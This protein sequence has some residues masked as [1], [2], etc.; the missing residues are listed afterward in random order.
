MLDPRK[1]FARPRQAPDMP[2]R[3]REPDVRQAEADRQREEQRET[4]KRA[5]ASLDHQQQAEHDRPDA[6]RRDHSHAEAH[7]QRARV[8]G[9]GRAR[10]LQ[11]P[12]WRLQDEQA[13]ARRGERQQHH[14]QRD[15][16]ERILHRGAEQSARH[17]DRDAHRREH[18]RDSEHEHD[19]Q[20][21]HAARAAALVAE[22][23]DRHADERIDAWRQIQREAAEKYRE[24]A[25]KPSV[26]LERCARL[27][28]RN[29]RHRRYRRRMSRLQPLCLRARLPPRLELPAR[30][31]C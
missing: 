30:L 6:W 21:H 13:E 7:Q 22:V 12:L 18:Q 26:I 31:S 2:G 3:H 5:A 25:E 10:A 28:R 20:V 27:R 15:E 9:M 4:E 8:A 23:C 24:E 29:R 14:R 19:R 11:H 1:P 16:Y 17:R